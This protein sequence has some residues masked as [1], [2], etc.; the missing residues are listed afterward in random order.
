VSDEWK[1]VFK[2]M[3]PGV[4]VG[5]GNAWLGLVRGDQ[6]RPLTAVASDTGTLV[7]GLEIELEPIGMAKKLRFRE[8]NY[9][10]FA[11]EEP[12]ASDRWARCQ[13]HEYRGRG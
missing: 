9:S 13:R 5:E 7:C 4:G 11:I 3:I 1:H 2:Q 8:K 12:G 6:A 10:A